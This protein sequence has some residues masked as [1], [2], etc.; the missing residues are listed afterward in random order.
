M[1]KNP[2]ANS[3]R[4]R[5]EP[6]PGTIP[7]VTEQLSPLSHNYW[8][9]VLEP[10]SCNYWS[11]CSPKRVLHKEKPLQW[12]PHAHLERSSCWPQTKPCT[13]TKTQHSQNKQIKCPYQEKNVSTGLQKILKKKMTSWQVHKST[14][15]CRVLL[16][17][18]L[19][20]QRLCTEIFLFLL[21]ISYFIIATHQ[22]MHP[23]VKYN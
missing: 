18:A 23:D 12:E 21:W 14:V 6:W 22:M 16:P 11:L 4:P 5:F 17:S 15:A 9:H 7:Q 20:W 3:K 10:G 2:P 13:A 1:V 19:C 8:T